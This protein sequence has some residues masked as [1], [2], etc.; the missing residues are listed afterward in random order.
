MSVKFPHLLIYLLTYVHKTAVVFLLQVYAY[1]LRL[2]FTVLQHSS[3][4]VMGTC[5]TCI[6]RVTLRW[7]QGVLAKTMYRQL[8]TREARGK[9]WTRLPLPN[10]QFFLPVPGSDIVGSTKLKKRQH[11]NKREE[12]GKW[13]T[14]HRPLYPGHALIFFRCLSPSRLPYHLIAWNRLPFCHWSS[15]L[16]RSTR[17]VFAV[18]ALSLINLSNSWCEDCSNRKKFADYI[19]N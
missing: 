3:R 4:L 14:L 12:T 18:V 5:I 11:E 9:D 15:P 8:R 19:K 7:I 13:K 17:V 16:I 6:Y 2:G 10:L 1:F